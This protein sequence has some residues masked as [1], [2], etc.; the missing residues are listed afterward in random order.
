MLGVLTVAW[1]TLLLFA[2]QG[3]LRTYAAM[4]SFFSSAP[5][6]AAFGLG[7]AAPVWIGAFV[8]AALTMNMIEQRRQ[9]RGT[10]AACGHSRADILAD[11]PCP[12]CGATPRVGRS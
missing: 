6:V 1:L 9:R 7:V 4:D 2:L 10:C 11:A 3:A 5:A 8:A 12:E